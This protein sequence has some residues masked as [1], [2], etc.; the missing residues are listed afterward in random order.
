MVKDLAV[1]KTQI[2][3]F[4]PGKWKGQVPK[5]IHHQRVWETLGLEEKLD[6][7]RMLGKVPKTYRGDVLD[8]VA[9]LLW[10]Y[11]RL[12]PSGYA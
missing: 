8:G 4:T 12:L 11:R 3:E 10:H 7:E 2:L 9:L 5:E 1:P 6:L